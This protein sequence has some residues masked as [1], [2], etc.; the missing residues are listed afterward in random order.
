MCFNS[1]IELAC[2]N[3]LLFFASR[4]ILFSGFLFIFLSCFGEFFSFYFFHSCSLSFYQVLKQILC[5][6]LKITLVSF[7]EYHYLGGSIRVIQTGNV[8]SSGCCILKPL[9]RK[10]FGSPLKSEIYQSQNS[11][12]CWPWFFHREHRVFVNCT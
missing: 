1:I 8:R 10:C 2:Q 5:A 6:P 3:D 11:F 4:L 7:A 9:L 12:I